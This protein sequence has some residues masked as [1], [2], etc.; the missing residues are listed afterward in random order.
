MLCCQPMLSVHSVPHLGA[1]NVRWVGWVEQA[2]DVR[3]VA[4]DT[5]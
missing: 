1:E 3:S 2:A 4:H 5:F